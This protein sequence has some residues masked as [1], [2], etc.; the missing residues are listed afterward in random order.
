MKVAWLGGESSIGGEVKHERRIPT[1]FLAESRGA[2][3]RPT[4]I[5]HNGT[6]STPR[7]LR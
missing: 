1:T 3:L 2:G 4:N 5:K 7:N 6:R